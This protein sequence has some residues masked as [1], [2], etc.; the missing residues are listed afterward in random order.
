MPMND[1]P[2]TLLGSEDHRDP[3][4][5]R[6]H[7]LP[8]VNLGLQAL[9]LHDVGKIG[10]RVFRQGLET[11]EPA[12]S[13]GERGMLHRLGDLLPP[14]RG[15]GLGV[16]EGRVASMGPEPLGGLG[17]T[18]H[19]LAKGQVVSLDQLVYFGYRGHPEIS[20]PVSTIR[21]AAGWLWGPRVSAPPSK[22]CP[23]V[24]RSS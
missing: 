19:E 2:C 21:P 14:A 10:G 1:L 3:K 11:Q 12:V 4:G 20:T 6:A 23:R 24:E 8:S 7:F 5:V 22:C 9:Y 13:T 15:G 18:L 16:G 17:V